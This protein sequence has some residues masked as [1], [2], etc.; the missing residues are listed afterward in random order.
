VASN[1]LSDVKQKVATLK[2]RIERLEDEV[3]RLR[4]AYGEPDMA[5]DLRNATNELNDALAELKATEEP[6]G[7]PQRR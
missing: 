5:D 1:E 3:Q 7:P 2:E 4:A 6:P